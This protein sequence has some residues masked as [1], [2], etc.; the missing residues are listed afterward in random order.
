VT[1]PRLC[2]AVRLILAV[3]TLVLSNVFGSAL[4]RTIL[5][6]EKGLP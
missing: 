5:T 6:A 3:V 4:R 1:D 2:G